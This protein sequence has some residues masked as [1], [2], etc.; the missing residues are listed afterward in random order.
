MLQ[1]RLKSPLTWEELLCVH[2]LAGLLFLQLVWLVC[3]RCQR[4][5]P[6]H[7]ALAQPLGVQPVRC[8][9]QQ[10]ATLQDVGQLLSP[11][12][13]GL[14]VWEGKEH[15][16]CPTIEP[17]L[18]ARRRR[19]WRGSRGRRGGDSTAFR[20]VGGDFLNKWLTV[21][22]GDVQTT[23]YRRQNIKRFRD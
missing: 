16:L 18:W 22:Q 9:P 2:Q 8:Q 23:V 13:L 12:P 3:I 21:V 17:F 7:S 10:N 20:A 15:G 4:T 6:I 14:G 1:W 5:F 11:T 19:G